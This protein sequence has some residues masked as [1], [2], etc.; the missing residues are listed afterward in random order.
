MPRAGDFKLVPESKQCESAESRET[1][2]LLELGGMDSP[3][4]R[5]HWRW[6]R[7]L[8]AHPRPRLKSPC[9][10]CP[11]DGKSRVCGSRGRKGQWRFVAA[12]S[13]MTFSRTRYFSQAQAGLLQEQTLHI[14]CVR[15]L[16][17]L[18]GSTG[19]H[20][21]DRRHTVASSLQNHH[22]LGNTSSSQQL[23]LTVCTGGWTDRA[24]Q[25]G[26]EGILE[27]EPTCA[28]DRGLD[29]GLK[30]RG[31]TRHAWETLTPMSQPR[32]L[33]AKSPRGGREMGSTVGV[34]T[35]PR[36]VKM[37]MHV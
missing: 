27:T 32:N 28:E 25:A 13:S 24:K 20:M 30:A 2:E 11:E 10:E 36:G 6:C 18:A 8:N 21:P 9:Y 1:T 22:S 4:V 37:D 23:R 17:A 16:Q 35:P 15:V 12:L 33:D 14:L 26:G 19:H 34:E 29:G 31:L 5:T 3:L 7:D